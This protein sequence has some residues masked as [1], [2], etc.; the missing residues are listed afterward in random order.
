MGKV[1]LSTGATVELGQAAAA[2]RHVT[3]A[4][5]SG[6]LRVDQPA[7][8]KEPITGFQRGD[9]IDFA[10]LTATSAVYS[11]GNLTLLNGATPVI[12]LAVSTPY[13]QPAFALAPDQSGGT[14]LTVSAPG[15]PLP[16]SD[17]NGDGTSDTLFQNNSG[18]IVV[19][20][21][22][23]PMSLASAVSAIRDRVGM[24]MER[25]IS[26]M[27]AIPTSCGRTGAGK[28]TFGS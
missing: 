14:F 11:S 21:M 22:K 16:S 7:L 25:E 24:S 28:L 9:V 4:D 17:F 23:G 27:T 18:Q 5:G 13:S 2:T 26:I 8:F 15:L 12:Q 10:A 19:W 6:T 1:I 20:D 3:F